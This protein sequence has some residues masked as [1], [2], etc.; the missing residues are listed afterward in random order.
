MPLIA[1]NSS[2][3]T[4]EWT[5][6][7]YA[8]GIYVVDVTKCTKNK[9]TTKENLGK[10]DAIIMANGINA[11]QYGK[12]NKNGFFIPILGNLN[13]VND[14]NYSYYGNWTTGIP[15]VYGCTVNDIQ[16]FTI[17]EFN[18]W[19]HQY[20]LQHHVEMEMSDATKIN[21]SDGTY[22]IIRDVLTESQAKDYAYQQLLNTYGSF[23]KANEVEINQ[24]LNKMSS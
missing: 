6:V 4:S 19:L 7:S 21:Y 3:S 22:D 1:S 9:N 13:I 2:G 16:E 18:D 20:L 23:Y 17:Q 8:Y 12:Y 24:S 14:N 10:Y 11:N 15:A 5:T